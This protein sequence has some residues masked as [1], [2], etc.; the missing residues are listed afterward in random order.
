V[1]SVIQLL[2]RENVSP[3]AAPEGGVTIMQRGGVPKLIAQGK[4]LD[5]VTRFSTTLHFPSLESQPTSTLH[6]G[7]L[8][9]GSPGKDSPFA[10]M[11]TFVPHLVARNLLP[12]P[13]TLTV[14]VE[15]PTK[16]GSGG[17][18]DRKTASTPPSLEA[19][20]ATD[21]GTVV[22]PSLT[23]GPY[24]TQDFALD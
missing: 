10:G 9:I 20:A 23:L 6:A 22:L 14:T 4:I 8:P 5:S 19:Y 11:G 2:E 12:T 1:L 18:S 17:D 16:R 15:Y 24:A 13:Q 7:G 3:S 21:A